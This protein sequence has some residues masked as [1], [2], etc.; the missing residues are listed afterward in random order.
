MFTQQAAGANIA[1]VI[2]I[3]IGVMFA[4]CAFLDMMMLIQ[5]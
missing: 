3:I 4:A 5:V 2:M 1:G